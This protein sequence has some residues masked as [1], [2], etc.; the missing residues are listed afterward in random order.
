M[1]AGNSVSIGI[2]M[3]T[4]SPLFCGRWLHVAPKFQSCC[5]ACFRECDV[6]AVGH[7]V[8][9]FEECHAPRLLTRGMEGY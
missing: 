6:A 1:R 8:E 4:R 7:W 3:L 9:F 5:M 2:E